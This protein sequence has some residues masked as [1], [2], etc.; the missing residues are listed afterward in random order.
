MGKIFFN[1]NQIEEWVDA[2]ERIRD[3]FGSEKALGYLIGEKF[4]N[5][6]KIL[7]SARNKVRDI[8]G[9][10]KKPNYNPIRQKTYGTSKLNENLDEIYEDEKAK[11]IEAEGLLVKFVFLVT[12]AFPSHEIRKYFQSHPRLGAMGHITSEEQHD[13]MVSTGAVEHSIDTEIE[14]ALIFGDM[15]KY[16]GIDA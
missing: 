9:E 1:D 7:H 4:Y 11:I 2:A 16:F 14:D 5:T 10:R 13:F 8:D 6:V 15:L 3:Q 12:Q